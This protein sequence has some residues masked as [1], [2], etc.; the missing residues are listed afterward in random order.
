[1]IASYPEPGYFVSGKNFMALVSIEARGPKAK[2]DISAGSRS[3][4]LA[5]SGDQ[6]ESALVYK[7]CTD[8]LSPNAD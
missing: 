8:A 4:K 1:V 3:P 2:L 7:E 5:K 6:R